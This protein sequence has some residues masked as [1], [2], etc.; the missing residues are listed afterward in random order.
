[1]ATSMLAN[2]KEKQT[3]NSPFSQQNGSFIKRKVFVGNP[4]IF[5]T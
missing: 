3:F 4:H 2:S 1:M 5:K